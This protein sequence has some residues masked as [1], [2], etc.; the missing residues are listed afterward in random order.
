MLHGQYVEIKKHGQ[1][2]YI[3][4]I[5]CIMFTIFLQISSHISTGKNQNKRE[6]VPDQHGMQPMLGWTLGPNLH[7]V[8]SDNWLAVQNPIGFIT[9]F[10]N[11][12]SNYGEF[13]DI[14]CFTFLF[15][16]IFMANLRYPPWFLREKPHGLGAS[17]VHPA[18]F[19]SRNSRP[20]Q[21]LMGVPT[22]K[23]K[24]FIPVWVPGFS[25]S[26]LK[27]GCIPSMDLCDTKRSRRTHDTP[28][29]PHEIFCCP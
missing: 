16:W 11:G 2:C 17:V 10:W 12:E 18:D 29:T 19:F 28:N 8:V 1:K 14:R 5:L 7:D 26:G 13:G 9:V 3:H 4:Q 21:Q 27:K 23:S 22:S 20:K 6:D 15:L 24:A 25:E